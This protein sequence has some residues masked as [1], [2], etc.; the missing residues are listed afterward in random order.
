MH[1]SW[2]EEAWFLNCNKN[3]PFFFLNTDFFSYQFC[4]KMHVLSMNRIWHESKQVADMKCFHMQS[5]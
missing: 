5:N 2:I 1:I 3:A 4:F